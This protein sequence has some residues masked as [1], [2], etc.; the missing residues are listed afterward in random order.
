M[1]RI[2]IIGSKGRMGMALLACAPNHREIQIVGQMDQGDDLAAI[3]NQCDVVVDFSSHTVTA[4]LVE[5][6]AKHGKAIVI[7]TTGHDDAAK[8][9]IGNRKS[10]IAN[11]KSQIANRKSQIMMW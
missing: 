3:I 1:T 8:S 11:Q 10:E 6:C 7:G 9:E 5:L 2:I 4:G